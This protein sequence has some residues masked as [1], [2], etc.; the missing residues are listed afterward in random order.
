[1]TGILIALLLGGGLGGQKFYPDDPLTREPE[2]MRV[3]DARFRKLNDQY[4]LFMHTLGSP[5]EQ[6]PENLEP[7]DALSINT[8]VRNTVRQPPATYRWTVS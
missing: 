7:I 8:S 1:M 4:D 5:G 6:Q 2:P 3:D